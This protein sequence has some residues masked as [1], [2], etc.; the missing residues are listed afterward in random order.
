MEAL[1]GKMK[2]LD[3]KLQFTNNEDVASVESIIKSLK[4]PSGRASDVIWEN[5][6]AKVWNRLSDIEKQAFASDMTDM[7]MRDKLKNPG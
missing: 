1:A 5:L 2:K 6:V 7:V 3:I 4:I